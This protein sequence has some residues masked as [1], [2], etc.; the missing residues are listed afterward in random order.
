MG[1]IIRTAQGRELDMDALAA[2]NKD[3]VALGNMKVNAAGDQLG[4]NGE[5]I[6]NS[7]ERVKEY[8]A[9][10]PKTTR[11]KVSVKSEDPVSVDL[12]QEETS[13]KSKS[14]AKEKSKRAKT[15]NKKIV[16]KDLP[17]GSIEI[18]DPAE[19]EGNNL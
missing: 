2:K 14:K 1:N 6:K 8:Y 16:E 3:K 7:N 18:I 11:E 12:D 4:R 10:N 5:V 19:D 17:D 15:S 13:T 9:E